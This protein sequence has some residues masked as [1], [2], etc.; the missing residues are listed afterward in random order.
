MS[1]PAS[2][3]P[4]LT[5]RESQICRLLCFG[6][7]NAEIART[8]GISMHTVKSHL[9]AVALKLG[10]PTRTEIALKFCAAKIPRTG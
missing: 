10:S 4:H 9:H 3:R 5:S 8:V 1:I 6:L 7:S 2:T